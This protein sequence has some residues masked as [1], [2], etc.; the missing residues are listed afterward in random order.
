[1]RDDGDATIFWPGIAVIMIFVIV[2]AVLLT[3]CGGET[4]PTQ[5]NPTIGLLKKDPGALE[6]SQSWEHHNYFVMYRCYDP[7]FGIICYANTDG[8]IVC[9][10]KE[11]LRAKSN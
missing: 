10:G 9:Y 5:S 6:C 11:E 8:G 2:V 3:S 1:M 7:E 4:D